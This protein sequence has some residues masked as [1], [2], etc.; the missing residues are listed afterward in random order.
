MSYVELEFETCSGR[1]KAWEAAV[2][3]CTRIREDGSSTFFGKPVS[4]GWEHSRRVHSRPDLL[5]HLERLIVRHH[6]EKVKQL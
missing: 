5:E 3:A 2:M 6:P 1:G 4:K